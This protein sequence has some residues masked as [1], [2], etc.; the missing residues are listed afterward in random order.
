MKL[1]T[2]SM[3]DWDAA[4][5]H[6]V[7]DPQRSWGL[8]V[9]DRLAPSPGERILDIGCG[10]GRLTTEISKRV[11]SVHLAAIDRSWNM[12]TEAKRNAEPRIAFVHAD[13]V[14]LPFMSGFDAVFSTA[15][16]HWVPD[17]PALFAEI[18]RVL[19]PGGRLVAQA[20]GGS[21]LARLYGR[22]A[23]L[24]DERDLAPYYKGWKDPWTFA[25]IDDTR[26]RLEQAGFTNV[27]VWLESTPTRLPDA[28]AFAEFVTTVCLRYQLDRLPPEKRGP[29]VQRI[30]R[31]AAGDEP[32]FT[33]D[34]WRLNMDAR[35]H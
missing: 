6:R 16:F 19:R 31:M 7:S 17:H 24:A 11:P 25:G 10:T 2:E 8:R 15:T 32:S 28:D 27:E 5:Y 14:E 9:L 30:T 12:L 34:Y 4:R 33:L 3:S 21:N 35:K 13:A 20:G 29:F 1:Y 23:A 18:H 26:D 22:T